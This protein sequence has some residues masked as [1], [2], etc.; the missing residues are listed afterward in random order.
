MRTTAV[1]TILA[2]FALLPFAGTGQ[3]TI[4]I[5]TDADTYQSGD[6]IEVA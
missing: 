3:P 6:T 2:V 1:C 4:T 5:Y